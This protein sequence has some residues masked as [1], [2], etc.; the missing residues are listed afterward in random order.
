M[1][2]NKERVNCKIGLWFLSSVFPLI[3]IYVCTKFNFNPFCTFQDMTQTGI[4]Y[5]NNKW[6]RGDNYVNIHG[7]IMVLPPTDIYL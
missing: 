2:S 4:H 7:R 1:E 6:L 5:E 3:N